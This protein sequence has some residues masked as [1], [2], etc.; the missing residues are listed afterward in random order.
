MIGIS[1]KAQDD[2]IKGFVLEETEKGEFKPI[3][4]ANVYWKDTLIGVTTDSFGY[5]K[6]GHYHSHNSL[7]IKFIGYEPDTV[8][9]TNHEELTIILKNAKHLD[10]VQVL[11]KKN[12]T[13]ISFLSAIKIED[14]GQQ[15]L[16]KAAC[17]NLSESFETNPS[18]D[19]H[20][21]DAVT[22]S[23]QIKMLG[24]AGKYVQ[25]NR[26]SIPYARG[27][28]TPYALNFIPGAWIE[29][30][31]LSKGTASVINGFEGIT[32]QINVELKK[33]EE[34]EKLHVNL[35]ANQGGRYEANVN[36]RI[37]LNKNISSGILMHYSERFRRIDWNN[38]G[39]M[40]MSLGP[41]YNLMNR[42]KYDN[43]KGLIG[44]LGIHVLRDNK[45]S[46]QMD[47]DHIEHEKSNSIYGAHTNIEREEVW[48]KLGYVFP[49]KKYKSIGGQLSMYQYQQNSIIGLN[50]FQGQ[51]KSI[52]ANLIYQT[53]ISNTNHKVRTGISMMHDIYND[54]LEYIYDSIG[55][56]RT[57]SWPGGFI[58]YTYSGTEN[59][60]L[61]SGLR[62]DQDKYY[63][64]II[65]PRLH[66][67]YTP[68]KKTSIRLSAGRAMRSVQAL[69][70]SLFALYSSRRLY[71][72]DAL[73]R[74]ELSWNYGGSFSYRFNVA[75]CRTG[76]LSIDMFRTHFDNQFVID[77]DRD[78]N[79]IFLYSIDGSYSNSLQAQLDIPAS[80]Q[81]DIRM[82]Y[83]LFDVKQK[84]YFGTYREAPLT[85]KHRAFLNLSYKT[86]KGLHIDGTLNWIGPKRLPNIIEYSPSFMTANMQISKTF[87]EV[88]DIYV[89]CENIGN[90]AQTNPI[91]SA[92]TP[93]D[94]GFDA[95]RIWGPI[96]GRIIYTGLRF[97]LN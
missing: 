93:F 86:T 84:F 41:Q 35:Y 17:C 60:T 71:F 22:G 5:F 59:F 14:M 39:F 2:F 23:K 15:E 10:E 32:G 97:T 82:A 75:G 29:S 94:S 8:E 83:R 25:I 48:A 73:F 80:N 51:Q 68:T 66:I 55:S 36:T 42:W 37:K 92:D 38:D 6:L 78:P 19:V 87:G 49:N 20:Y 12:T 13:E 64:H 34:S 56:N 63:T 43:N 16:Y 81:L 76:T 52:Y 46:G 53:I 44:Q 67:C 74:P 47:Y 72:L 77:L 26:E 65:S 27:L 24:L 62:V 28:I 89:G 50:Q 3:A 18:V 96:F 88:L 57:D 58:E 54:S 95:N 90:F 11:Y 7:V 33:P 9:I 91:Y 30:I 85:A 4:F 45:I 70:E 40:D 79:K 31:Q 61:V 69:T 21:S 1:S